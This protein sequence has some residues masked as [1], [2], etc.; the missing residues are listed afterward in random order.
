M[1]TLAVSL[2]VVLPALAVVVPVGAAVG[3]FLARASGARRAVVDALVL[4]S[5]VLPPTVV[6]YL[7]LLLFGRYGP[8]GAPLDRLFGE[9]LVFSG[10]GASLAVAVVSLPLMAKGAEA[11][12]Q[13][14]DHELEEVAQANGL[15]ARATFR[16]VTLPLAIPGLGVAATLAMLRAFGELGATLTFAGYSR[17]TATAPLEVYFAMQRGDDARALGISLGLVAKYTS[18]LAAVLIHAWSRRP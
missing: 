13:R 18:S 15:G 10:T 2:R 8:F 7:L 12:F 5:L 3:L 17:S 14:V 1:S 16:L 11:A 9:R 6:G 4:V